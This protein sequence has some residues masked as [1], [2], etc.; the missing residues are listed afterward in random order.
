MEVGADGVKVQHRRYLHTNILAS[1]GTKAPEEYIS[2]TYCKLNQLCG[3]SKMQ[4]TRRRLLY[5]FD[6]AYCTYVILVSSQK[7]HLKASIIFRV[8]STAFQKDLILSHSI[9]IVVQ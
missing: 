1:K 9:F 5:R 7:V 4:M 3:L 2:A 6:L 8:L